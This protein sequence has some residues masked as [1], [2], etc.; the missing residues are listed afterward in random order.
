[1]NYLQQAHR[2]ENKPWMFLLTFFLIAGLFIY[3]LLFFLFFSEGID[4]SQEQQT[5]F[6]LVPSQN[7]WLAFN[8]LPFVFWLG[9][10]FLFL[11]TL[12][13]R[14]MLSLPEA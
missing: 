10:L 13:H 5:L 12:H 7:F 2:G 6:E 4:I 8:L 11:K 1:M 9:L 3:N 14:I